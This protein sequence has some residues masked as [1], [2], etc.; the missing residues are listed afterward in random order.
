M[1]IP[2]PYFKNIPKMGNLEMDHIFL[3]NGYPVLFTCKN[4]NRIF[5][6]ICRTVI[7]VQKWVIS[8][9]DLQTLSNLINNVTS[10]YDAFKS[11]KNYAC[12]V[13][14]DKV[15]K[16][17]EY[18]V[19]KCNMLSDSDLPKKKVFLDDEGESLEYLNKVENRILQYYANHIE[20]IFASKEPNCSSVS[21]IVV[22]TVQNDSLKRLL[23]VPVTSYLLNSQ[24]TIKYSN[25]SLSRKSFHPEAPMNQEY[26]LNISAA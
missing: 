11:G 6:C 20:S 10:I 24:F 14:W 16:Q 19:L 26:K 15:N 2:N 12:I 4:K 22:K 7:D 23:D 3:E 17:E 21:Q 5:L 9:I 1:Y 8:E 25:M 18:E 13:K